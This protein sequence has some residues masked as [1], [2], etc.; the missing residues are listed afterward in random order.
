MAV[1]TKLVLIIEYDGIRYHGFQLQRDLPTVQ[2]ELEQAIYKLTGERRR[3]LGASRTDTGVHARAQVVSF[4]TASS[5]EPEIF[6]RGLNHYLCRDV[7]VKAA[8][9]VA[10]RVD[11]R[12]QALSREYRYYILNAEVRSPLRRRY[13]YQVPYPLDV[14]AM[15]RACRILIGKHDMASFASKLEDEHKS[16]VREVYQAGVSREEDLVVFTIVASSFLPH[17][18]RNT[19]GV[20]LGVGSGKVDIEVVR[21]IMEKRQPGLAGPTV[22]GH[23]LCLV[24]IEYPVPFEEM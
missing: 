15:D 8:Y 22:P 4:R 17:Q 11:V 10:D 20:L 7:A 5:L 14:A 19:V 3:V 9:R 16:T 13:A 21:S 18:V 1:A 2:G 6:V 12:R 23:G 24:K